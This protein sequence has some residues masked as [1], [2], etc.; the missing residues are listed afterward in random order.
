MSWT[1]RKFYPDRTCFCGTVFTPE[2]WRATYCSLACIRA[3][4]HRADK[5]RDHHVI[6]RAPK[7]VIRVVDWNDR[8]TR[9]GWKA[10]MIKNPF[11]LAGLYP[12]TDLAG[13]IMDMRKRGAL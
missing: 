4:K 6:V 1:Q 12:K 3:A 8:S 2:H 10:Y 11:Y 7:P 5:T 13:A 9:Y